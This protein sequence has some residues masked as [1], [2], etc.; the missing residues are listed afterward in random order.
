M[1]IPNPNLAVFFKNVAITV[2]DG[3]HIN[4][5]TI[6]A[7]PTSSEIKTEFKQFRMWN[8]NITMTL[9]PNESGT[10]EMMID[11]S[12]IVPK[13]V[14]IVFE[15][16]LTGLITFK[17]KVLNANRYVSY[18]WDSSDSFKIYLTLSLPCHFKRPTLINMNI[19][20]NDCNASPTC[21]SQ[22][23]CAKG[24]TCCGC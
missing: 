21:P 1:S 12:D 5:A 3:S 7:I 2:T 16:K 19:N 8:F 24:N 15:D 4:Y 18:K 10:Y 14:Q 23:G 17:N 13:P 9:E 22:S 11:G 6:G 20:I